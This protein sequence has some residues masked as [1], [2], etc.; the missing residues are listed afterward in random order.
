MS[1]L[2]GVENST[3]D[4]EDA[5]DYLNDRIPLDESCLLTVRHSTI[6]VGLQW[7]FLL[8]RSTNSN[9]LNLLQIPDSKLK[10]AVN[11]NEADIPSELITQCVATLLMIQV[12]I[13]WSFYPV[14]SCSM[15]IRPLHSTLKYLGNLL[16]LKNDL[17]TD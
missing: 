12:K 1:S 8:L 6:L 15:Q 3:G 13:L 10:N 11:G 2:N 17:Q 9:P 5:I 14:F 16:H 4:V 7:M